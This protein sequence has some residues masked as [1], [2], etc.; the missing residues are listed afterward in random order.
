MKISDQV[1]I[2]DTTLRDGEQS[3][4]CS[5]SAAQKLALARSL[6][7]LGVDIIEAGFPAAS[8]DDFASVAA[9]ASEVRNSRVAGL[10]RCQ[11]GDIESVARALRGCAQPRIHVFIATSDIHMAHK[12]GMSRAQVL[13]AA[14]AG[15]EFARSFCEDVE[16]SAEDASRSDQTFLAEIFA[17]VADA[18]ASTLNVPD[19]VGYA[20]PSE[21][22]ALFANLRRALG[23]RDVILSS[24]CHDDL[25]L[26]VANSLAA[27]ENGARQVECT[28]N[29]IGER[30]GNA[31]LEEIVMALRTRAP[32][33]GLGTRIRSERLFPVSRQVT[34][35]TGSAVARNKAIVG[36]NAFAHESGIHQHGMLKHR[37]TYE[38]MRPE[39]VGVSR[40]QLVLGKHSG[41]AALSD[42]L[43]TLGFVLDEAA[44]ARAFA[45]F[46]TLAD[47]KKE[48]FDADLEAIVLGQT[49]DQGGPWQLQALQIQGAIGPD[50]VPSA[51]VRMAHEDGR[52][53]TEAA[54]GD[55]PVHAIFAAI[56]RASGLEMS[57][58]QFQIRSLTTGED[59]QGEA[60][61]E[62]HA[63]SGQFH[64]R[65]ISTDILEASALAFIEVANRIARRQPVAETAAVEAAA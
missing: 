22:G 34:A 5:M 3:P 59:A 14:V 58:Y 65:A 4:G 6:E 24:H 28:V 18:G 49:S 56:T 47:K 57:L 9:I 62:V 52:V 30:A 60:R 51:S 1:R 2:F 23:D 43:R 42:R 41:R 15:V 32:H 36:E 53:I 19:T 17:A 46:K 63:G 44:L 13:D 12:L 16:F 37:E 27:I 40:S 48:V 11:R 35:I 54:A 38:I 55:G 31:A 25:G 8:P 45:A 7:D 29:G 50:A 20:I 10:A 61:V 39:D 21:Y 33:Y 26:A 64:G